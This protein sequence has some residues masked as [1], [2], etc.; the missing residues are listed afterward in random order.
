MRGDRSRLTLAPQLPKQR[1]MPNPMPECP[2][3]TN[4]TLPLRQSALKIDVMGAERQV[5][6]VLYRDG[7]VRLG[8]ARQ[9]P[10]PRGAPNHLHI[11][12]MCLYI[13]Y[14]LE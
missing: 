10:A 12:Q 6:G 14:Y 5:V 13:L 1:A 9:Q 8:S 2:P 11:D 3:V 7:T 4:A